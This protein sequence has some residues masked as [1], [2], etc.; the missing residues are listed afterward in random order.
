MFPIIPQPIE[1][2]EL[3]GGPSELTS[4]T[5]LVTGDSATELGAGVLLASVLGGLLGRSMAVAQT[6]RSTTV[7]EPG[8]IVLRLDP[9]AGPAGE[10]SEERYTLESRGGAVVLAAPS[11][12]GLQRAMATLGQLLEPTAT[13]GFRVP[14]VRVVDAPRYPWRGLSLDVARHFF[15]VDD[16]KRVMGLMARYKFNVLHLHLSDDQGW[17]IEI[18]SRPRLTQ[19]GATTSV[20]GGPGGFFT[21]EDFAELQSFA[22]ARGITI[23]PEVDIPGHTNAALHAYPELNADGVAKPVYTGIEVGFSS[24][25]AALPATEEFLRDVFGDLAA[26]TDGPWVHLGGDE[27]LDTSK[28]DYETL[29]AAAA[30]IL[31]DAGKTPVGWQEF[32]SSPAAAGAVVQ[33]WHMGLPLEPI[34]AAAR[35][36]AQVLL[37]PAEHAYLD[38]KYVADFPL[39]LEWA[40]HV[41]LRDSY[42]WEPAEVLRGLDPAAIVGVEAAV[43][44]E[45][46]ATMAELST[47]LL[48]RLTAVAEAAWSQPERR[49]WDSYVERVRGQGWRWERQGMS[50]H[51]SPQVDWV[52]HDGPG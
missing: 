39:G 8:D 15:G 52:G 49:D 43:W 50:W 26:M 1:V 40:G 9:A 16:V 18:P 11:T 36:G 20:D 34:A 13:G 3:D 23:V 21:V 24:L 10:S 46:L 51:P 48:P 32:A 30:T 25:D 33:V 6:T 12:D 37:S 29:V 44:T 17:R 5:R 45:T 27:A 38:M 14:A 41:E 42:D 7:P 28:E 35:A 19:L 4:Q 22:R 2:T 47:M 31:R